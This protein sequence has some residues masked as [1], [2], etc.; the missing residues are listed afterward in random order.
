MYA[1]SAQN[2]L[3]SWHIKEKDPD[4]DTAVIEAVKAYPVDLAPHP[5]QVLLSFALAQHK[6]RGLDSP[7]SEYIRELPENCTTTGWYWSSEEVA[8]TVSGLFGARE[9][10]LTLTNFREIIRSIQASSRIFNV[11]CTCR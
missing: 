1:I 2:T 3:A 6:R 8:C 5:N 7:L 11:T 4:L 9:A 10:Q